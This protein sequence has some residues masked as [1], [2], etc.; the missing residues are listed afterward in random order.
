MVFIKQNRLNLPGLTK[1]CEKIAQEMDINNELRDM[2]MKSF[3]KFINRKISQYNDNL[4]KNEIKSKDYKKIKQFLSE[5]FELKEYFKIYNV[6]DIRLK[7]RI[8]TMM[9]DAKTNFKNK[10]EYSSD[11][12]LC[13]SCSSSIETQSHLLWCPAYQNLRENK[14]L[15]NDRDLINYIRKVLEIRQDL[16]LRR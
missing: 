10:K 1:E 7:F 11:L 13:D 15:N 5:N 9:V 4:L 2:D 14:N 16:K 3:K 8:R 12:W 6:E